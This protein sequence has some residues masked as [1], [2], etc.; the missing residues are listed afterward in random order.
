MPERDR[1]DRVARLV[2][3][4]TDALS[5][6]TSMDELL[7]IYLRVAR[8]ALPTKSFGIYLY[9][10]PPGGPV[11]SATEGVSDVF[12]ARYEDCGRSRDPVL[13]RALT[14]GQ[15]AHSAHLMPLDE[16]QGL[17]VYKEVL[18]LHGMRM[19][20]EAPVMSGARVLGTLNFADRE[21]GL[22][23]SP[24][25][26]AVASALGRV[27]GSVAA[28]MRARID[29]E[30]ER[31]HALAALDLASEALVITDTAT[32]RRR[33]NDSARRLLREVA[34][35]DPGLWLE[36]T[37]AAARSATADP[38]QSFSWTVDLAP[39]DVRLSLRSV[40]GPPGS[41][42]L[43]AALRAQRGRA[44]EGGLPPSVA[45]ALSPREQEVAR[46]AVSGFTDGQIATKVFLSP[47]TVKQH[48]K[49]VYR[50]LGISSRGALTRLAL[51]STPEH[52]SRE[53]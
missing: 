29:V 2:V 53:G 3:A 7:E 47:Y 42:V 1:D 10:R 23:A 31:D 43:I 24:S 52:P 48:L 20:L 33:L 21:P 41:G 30:R 28:G 26:V 15:A 51:G 14:T 9:E 11:V 38:H 5:G 13:E 39:K 37:M 27:V 6:A 50:K 36:D 17:D 12:L 45:A 18:G 32:G 44:G 19:V 25:D 22:L 40:P 49:A 35:D 16:W 8:G 4:A 46:L 34:P